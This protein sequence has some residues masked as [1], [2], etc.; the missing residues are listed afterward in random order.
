MNVPD[1]IAICASTPSQASEFREA[2]RRR[3]EAGDYPREIEF[4][5][6]SDPEGGRIG[7]GGGTLHAL[8]YLPEDKTTL[9]IHAGGENRRLPAWAPEGK[10]FAPVPVPSSTIIPPVLLDLQI[11]LFL[12]YP[13]QPGELVVTSGDVYLDFDVESVRRDRGEVCGF[14]VPTGFAEGSRHGVFV[15]DSLLRNVTG[16]FQKESVD[17]LRDK[18]ALPGGDEC[19]LDIGIVSFDRRGRE[20]L[21]HLADAF[22]KELSEG[23]IYIDLYLEILTGALSGISKSEFEKLVASHSRLNADQRTVIRDTMAGANLQ[24]VVGRR[25]TFLHY[26]TV[27][28]IPQTA[29]VLADNGK[30][31]YP[32]YDV[33]HRCDVAHEQYP[34][35]VGAIIVSDSDACTVTAPW[36]GEAR[37]MLPSLVDN[38]DEFRATMGGGNLVTGVQN[39]SL[40]VSLPE[41]FA[42]DGRAIDARSVV[43]VYHSNDSFKS[44]GDARSLRVCNTPLVVWLEAR[45]ISPADV[46]ISKTNIDFWDLQLWPALPDNAPDER[47]RLLAGYWDVELADDYWRT[48]LLSGDRWSLRALNEHASLSDREILRADRRRRLIRNS[49]LSGRGW[50]SLPSQDAVKVFTTG[51]VPALRAFIRNET[52]ELTGAYRA[53]VIQK[54]D[55]DDRPTSGA[56]SVPYLSTLTTP[57]L[58]KRSVKPDQIVWARS[59]VRMDFGGGW[60]DT[61]PYTLREGGRVCNV[62]I[63]LNGQPPVQ[64]FC[65]PLSKPEIRFHSIDLGEGERITSFAALEDYQNPSVP[66]ALPRAALCILGFTRSNHPG[67]ELTDVLTDMGGGVEITLLAAVPKG[68]GL[69]TSSILSATLLAALERFFGVFGEQHI[70]TGELYRQVLQME[71]MLTTGGGWQDQIGGV[72]GGVKYTVSTPG[73]RP[74]ISVYQ[75]DPWLFEAREALDRYT[76]YYTGITRLAKNILQDVVDGFNSMSPASLFTVRRIGALAD[77]AREAFSLR[78]ID[79]F[80]KVVDESWKQNKLIHSSTTNPEIEEMLGSVTGKYE[81][82]KLLGAGGGGYGF[83]VSKSSEQADR[84]RNGLEEWGAAN[85]GARLVDLSLNTTG[86]EVTVS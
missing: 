6:V 13:W 8:S 85:S 49:I 9:L 65:R 38:C 21:M 66:F 55:P 41:G 58:L 44:N 50:Q 81:S 63:N 39:V 53:Q 27:G 59:P 1:I 12:R 23:T 43:A 51:D 20:R 70:N 11:A 37:P 42:L 52:D 18:A 2:I 40:P 54:L 57:P 73:L 78:D 28:D 64:V 77:A 68:S 62:A 3:T 76:L 86:L 17:T 5:V 61:P 72:A 80:S 25:G 47:G 79:R 74:D 82:M 67:R 14:S 19:A 45:R 15:F 60:T 16:Y 83:F 30:A 48:W 46:R 4:L 24:G 69:G 35:T 33:A 84:L 71:Q 10:L 7:S 31:I 34:Q 32:F 26:G 36:I 29:A 56:I 22:S 75:L